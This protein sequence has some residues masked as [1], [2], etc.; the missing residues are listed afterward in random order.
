MNRKNNKK[1]NAWGQYVQMVLYILLGIVWGLL[2]IKYDE[3][4]NSESSLEVLIYIGMF[5][6]MY[7]AILMHIVIHEAGHLIF[8]LISGYKFSSFRIF[9]FMWIKENRKI[10]LKRLS[11]AGTGGQCLM[12]PPDMT[13]GKFP[14]TMYNL[15]GSLMNTFAAF[16][17][18]CLFFIIADMPLFSTIVLIFTAVGFCIALVNGIP[19]RLGIIDNDGYNAFALSKNVDAMKS[20]WVQMKAC[21]LSNRGIRAKDMPAEWFDIPSDE[22]MKNSMVAAQGVFACNRLMDAQLF[23]EADVL[24]SHMLEI[25]SGMVD[26]HRNLMICDR[27]CVELISENRREVI[28]EMLSK[29]QKKFMKQMKSFPTV[30]RTEYVFAL[31][32][33][34]DSQKAEKIKARFEKCAK[35]YPSQSD[36]QS[37]RELMEFA[38][39]R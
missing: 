30:I 33:E 39:K 10:K 20:F 13:E 3:N 32:Y 25:D 29:E 34:K 2:I 1:Q 38:E 28:D 19:M 4:T 17:S 14:V 9:S 8:G 11:I 15:G 5:I 24:M 6:F 31:L 18:L 12:D 7:V 26:L 35:T 16:C 27:M 22:A 21:A 23:E 36:I 37:E